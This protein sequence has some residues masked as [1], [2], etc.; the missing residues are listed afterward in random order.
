MDMDNYSHEFSTKLKS[1]Q[2]GRANYV[3]AFLPKKL[4]REL[5]LSEN[6]R[7]RIDGEINGFRFNNA[8]HPANGK[9]YV[10]VPK[11]TRT[12]C[13]I[14]LGSEVFI[15]FNVGDQNAVDVPQELSRALEV[16]E[17]ANSVW[18]ELTPGKRR[19]FAYRVN[20]AKRRETRE[21]RVDEVI[22]HLLKLDAGEKIQRRSRWG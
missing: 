4:I 18:N 1:H 19:G 14:E 6:P 13:R 8:L 11:R 22:E 20:S 12:K 21:N 7:L 9:W 17:R 15:Q 5:P 3:V 10:L 2:F 16:N